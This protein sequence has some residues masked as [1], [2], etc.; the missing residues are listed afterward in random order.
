MASQF[1]LFLTRGLTRSSAQVWFW[2]SLLML[3]SLPIKPVQAQTAPLP[4]PNVPRPSLPVPG[5]RDNEPPSVQPLP[6]QTPPPQLPPPSELLQPPTTAPTTPEEVPSESP[7]TITVERFE[8]TGSTVFSAAEF[9]KV[10]APFT[11]RP[12][13][14]AELFQARTAVTQLYIDR[15]Y[16]T[17]GAYIPP[18]KLQG[19]VVEIRVV[20]GGLEDIKVTGTRRLNP[21]YVSSRIAAATG[22]PL[23][24]NRLLEALQ[25]LQ[26]NPLIQSLSAE[27][28][29]GSRAGESLLEVRITEARTTNFQ[30]GLDNARSPSVGTDRRRA[31]LSEANLLGFGD[32]ISAAYTNTDGSNAWDF[33]YTLP[34][35]PHNTT[36][37]FSVGTSTSHV[38]EQPFDVL[39]IES[40]SSYQE[41]TLRQPLLQTP[42]RELA[43]GLTLTRRQTEASLNP[44]KT[45][46]IPFPSLGSDAEG[47]V[48][49]NALRF[50]QEWTQRSSQAVFAVRSQFSF[51]LNAF[52]STINEIP[53]DSRFF[54]W[55]GQAQWV[56]LLAPDTL[57]LLR[58][59]LQVSDRPLV[60]VEQFTLG[61][62]DSIRGYRQ[63][64]LLT[65]SGFFGSAEVRIPI[66]RLPNINTLLQLAPFV[67]FG[68]AWNYS[69]NNPD[70]H[71]LASVG[72]GLR[73]QVSDRI[74]A[75][76]D[77]GIPLV[78]IPGSKNNLQER[79]IYFSIV[80]NPF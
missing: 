31:Q 17:S 23:N 58:G 6:E 10:T 15:G 37:S 74:T 67:D 42:N 47:K 36:L 34:L 22:K 45:G 62:Q 25:L 18:Q 60:P 7:Q 65:D 28:S 49:V 27:L 29:A 3:S 50:F 19:G 66:L 38:I 55:R 32:S 13:T 79:G 4:Q 63:D 77:W 9:A 39:R 52:D 8:V 5:S 61:G 51:G 40:K 48:R 71:T 70:P 57:L 1:F 59:D 75:R 20:E 24:R 16:I 14:L 11:K 78:S 80:V 68:T 26:L 69:G 30:V 2:L 46:E 73:L 43:L 76:F 35:G 53:P 21:G 12:I 33:N 44:F 56:R 72:L 54:A 64:A 41:F